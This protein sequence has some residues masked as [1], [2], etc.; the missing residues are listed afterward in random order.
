MAPWTVHEGDILFTFVMTGG[1]TLEGEGKDPYRLSPGD[2]FVIPPGM[3]TRYADATPDLE[4]LEVT[5]PGNPATRV[6]WYT[7]RRLRGGRGGRPRATGL[8]K[9]AAAHTLTKWSNRRVA[10]TLLEAATAVRERAYAPYSRFKV[11]AALRSTSGAVH[12]GCNVE[13][14]A[15]PEGTCAE[16]GAIAAMIAGG[17]YP[18]CRG[19]RDRRQPGAGAPLRWLPPEDRRVCGAGCAGD[20]VHHGRQSRR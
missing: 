9:S 3:A 6:C 1:M 12:V 17:R 4:L 5:L 13:N 15:Y 10:M 18:D 19:L 14:V 16:A 20:A 7:R 11:G 2:A 8:R